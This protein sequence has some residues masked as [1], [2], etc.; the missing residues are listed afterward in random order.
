MIIIRLINTIIRYINL[1]QIHGMQIDKKKKMFIKRVML[2][3][4]NLI[5]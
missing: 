4:R 5:K 2:I 1:G 3:N